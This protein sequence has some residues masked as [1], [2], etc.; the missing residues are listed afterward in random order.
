MRSIPASPGERSSENP[1]RH[2]LPRRSRIIQPKSPVT[3]RPLPE[4]PIVPGQRR[5][6][7]ADDRVYGGAWT[8]LVVRKATPE[9]KA[10][11]A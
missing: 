2:S 8:R 7:N 3:S 6:L 4:D 10:G 1:T 9:E 11:H 5:E